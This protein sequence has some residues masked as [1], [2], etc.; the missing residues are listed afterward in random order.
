[1]VEVE[2]IQNHAGVAGEF[3]GDNELTLLVAV[4]HVMPTVLISDMK[5]EVSIPFLD[6][7]S[8]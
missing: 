7:S 2:Y 3:I 8:H 5:L 4:G 1:M 6:N